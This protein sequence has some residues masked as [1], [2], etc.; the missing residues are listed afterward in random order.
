MSHHLR[1]YKYLILKMVYLETRFRLLSEGPAVLNMKTLEDR[2]KIL[3][4]MGKIK[5]TDK[6][7]DRLHRLEVKRKVN[8]VNDDDV[9]SKYL[10]AL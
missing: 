8:P 4:G 1:H 7:S 6:L 10:Y 5:S 3:E 2:L 9:D